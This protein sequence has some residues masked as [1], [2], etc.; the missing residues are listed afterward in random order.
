M[1]GDQTLAAEYALGL[2]E[3]EELLAARARVASD[4]LF[5][6]EVDQW[7]DRLAPLAD[8]IPPRLP[9][10][11]VWERI[12]AELSRD[13]GSAEV[14][15][16]RR[17]LR[18]WQWAGGLSA[19]AALVLAFLALPQLTGPG[20]TLPDIAQGP[21][22]AGP[23][24]AANMPIAGTPLRLDFTYLPAEDSLL[25]GAIGLT[26]DGVH[27]H[28]IWFVPPE[29]ELVSLGIVTP[30]KVVA[31]DVPDGVAQ[32]LHDGSQLVLTREPLGGK[33]AD[34]GAGPVVA[35][36]RFTAI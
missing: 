31:H 22:A 28:E 16:L 7:Q 6:A 13:T 21:V 30:G 19:A 5:A 3:G 23:P 2:L 34:A 25:V 1:T 36:A 10:A 35:E 20:D 11:E 29:G 32:A 8:H 14:V 9:R 24:L 4:A 17:S 12:E 27:D 18:R 15:S 33:P 26:A